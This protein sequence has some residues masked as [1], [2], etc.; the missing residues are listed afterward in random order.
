MRYGIFGGVFNPV[1]NGHLVIAINAL[2]FLKL[3]KL[4]IVP[5][6]SPPHKR[7]DFIVP[8][9]LR[10]SWVQKAFKGLKKVEVVDL[11]R[12][13]P[14]PSYS[15]QTVKWFTNNVG[16]SPFFIVGEDSL[17]YI[18]KWYDYRTL[19]DMVKL[20]VYPRYCGRPFEKHAREVMGEKYDQIIWLNTPL[21]QLSS[22]EIRE[23]LRKG[24]SVKGMVP[25]SLEHD[26]RRI[27]G[28]EKC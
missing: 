4:Y 15:V 26:I 10:F 19:L 27:Y 9:E 6:F 18:E 12:R 23:R 7:A 14:S 22:T 1:H 8:F 20:V 24:L 16:A 5:S 13:L 28:R 21:I 11:E 2:E 25:E 3:D 17:S